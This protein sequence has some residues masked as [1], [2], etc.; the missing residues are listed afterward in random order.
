MA[1]DY[2][3]A[4]PYQ[5]ETLLRD[6]YWSLLYLTHLRMRCHRCSPKRAV[7]FIPVDTTMSFKTVQSIVQAYHYANSPQIAKDVELAS[8][9]GLVATKTNVLRAWIRSQG[10]EFR[11]DSRL[12]DFVDCADSIRKWLENPRLFVKPPKTHSAPSELH[13]YI[14]VQKKSVNHVVAFPIPNLK[15]FSPEVILARYQHTT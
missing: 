9:A 6:L 15:R 1:G 12:A 2:S 13:N 4:Q 3:R 10:F 7:C 14:R 8:R 11:H 5:S